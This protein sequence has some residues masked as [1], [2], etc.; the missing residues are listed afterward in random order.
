MIGTYLY[1]IVQA[2]KEQI[3]KNQQEIDD[4]N[5]KNFDGLLKDKYN[6]LNE[7]LSH[8]KEKE[9]NEMK[10]RIHEMLKNIRFKDGRSIEEAK[11]D[12]KNEK[13]LKKQADKMNKMEEEIKKKQE[14]DVKAVN[15]FL[16]GFAD[17]AKNQVAAMLE[18][19]EAKKAAE[20]KK[21]E[22][23]DPKET[24]AESVRGPNKEV[25][26]ESMAHRASLRRKRDAFIA[27]LD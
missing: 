20:E 26:E 3:E 6:S 2:L 17:L 19:K 24:I 10:A 4:E 5:T 9:L 18:K 15:N 7:L 16:A 22:K 11:S 27:S 1:P 21:K 12:I 23:E 13:S 25:A 14:K 8:G